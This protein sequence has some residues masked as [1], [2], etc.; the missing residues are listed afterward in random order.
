MSLLYLHQIVIFREHPAVIRHEHLMVKTLT[1]YHL[2]QRLR[3]VY[4][5]LI[6]EWETATESRV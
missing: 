1:L 3:E 4:A 2:N 5:S 6:A